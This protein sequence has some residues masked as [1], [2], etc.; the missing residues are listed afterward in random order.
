MLLRLEEFHRRRQLLTIFDDHV[1]QSVP[2]IRDLMGIGIQ[3]YT[4]LHSTE[5]QSFGSLVEQA[6]GLL[7]AHIKDST[8]TRHERRVRRLQDIAQVV[9]WT[10][11]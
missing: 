10:G 5:R 3:E 11:P 6:I 1:V 9:L 2:K 4:G 8:V 7:G